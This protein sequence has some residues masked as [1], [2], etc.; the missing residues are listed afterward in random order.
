MGKI[1]NN[2]EQQKKSQRESVVGRQTNVKETVLHIYIYIYTKYNMY[3]RKNSRY[4]GKY[5]KN[6]KFK[7]IMIW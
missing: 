1:Y 4:Q 2:W 3:K 7:K 5:M 6:E